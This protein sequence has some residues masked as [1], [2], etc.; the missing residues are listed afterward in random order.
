MSK[1]VSSFSP[2][3]LIQRGPIVS[4][5]SSRNVSPLARLF[6][7]F[8]SF[9]ILSQSRHRKQAYV[10]RNTSS[11]MHRSRSRRHILT[12]PLIRPAARL[13]V[14]LKLLSC[15]TQRLRSLSSTS[16][17]STAT[18]ATA[19]DPA[20]CAGAAGIRRAVWNDLWVL[21]PCAR[22]LINVITAR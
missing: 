9:Y 15:P 1:K 21:L 13:I 16:A 17:Y 12:Q 3:P 10:T 11:W 5:T 4:T 2:P 6:A 19:T 22:I 18:R 14:L 20:A 7:I 8:L